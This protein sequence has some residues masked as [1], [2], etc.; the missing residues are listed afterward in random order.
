MHEFN[1]EN[2][3]LLNT[4]LESINHLFSKWNCFTTNEVY[5]H[6]LKIL[7]FSDCKPVA[8]LINPNGKSIKD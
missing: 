4:F 6:L 3:G 1:I 5:F 8:T 7:V 2:L